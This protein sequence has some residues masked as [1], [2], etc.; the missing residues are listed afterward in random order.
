MGI[1][2]NDQEEKRVNGS[3]CCS[4]LDNRGFKEHS[5]QRIS[6]VSK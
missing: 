4:E 2:D 1:Q 6:Y 3:D 5:G